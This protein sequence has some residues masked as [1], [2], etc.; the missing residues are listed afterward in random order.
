[1][2]EIPIDCSCGSTLWKAECGAHFCAE[3]GKIATNNDILIENGQGWCSVSGIQC[4][5]CKIDTC[6]LQ[7][8]N[9]VYK[10]V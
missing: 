5:D 1:M 8:R 2:S 9:Y 3:C 7:G 6:V 10:C 4:L